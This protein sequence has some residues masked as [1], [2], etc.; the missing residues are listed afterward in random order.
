MNGAVRVDGFDPASAKVRLNRWIS[1]RSEMNVPAGAKIPCVLA[2]PSDESAERA[3]RWVTEISRLARLESLTTADAVPEASAQI[4]LDEAVIALPLAGVID[5]AAEKARLNK[6]LEK[7]A[8]DIASIEGRLNNPGF[9]AK[10]PPEVIEEAK[11]RREELSQRVSQVKDAL[12]RLEA[13]G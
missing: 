10:A 9:T 5:F 2:H 6:E 12:G 8:K 4:V 3:N 1:V 13:M 11:E 7:T